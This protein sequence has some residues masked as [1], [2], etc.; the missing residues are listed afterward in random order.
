MASICQFEFVLCPVSGNGVGVGGSGVEVGNGV[1]VATGVAGATVSVGSGLEV[2]DGSGT[3]VTVGG[4]IGEGS[5]VSTAGAGVEEAQA[6]K[7]M[8]NTHRIGS[9]DFLMG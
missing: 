8:I 3:G 2:A 7:K 4:G 9:D 1:S 6:V 5:I